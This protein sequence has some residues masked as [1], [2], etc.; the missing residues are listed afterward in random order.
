MKN[1]LRINH[2]ERKIVMD[3]TFAKNAEDT[4][5]EEYAHLQNVRRDYPSYDVILRQIK[6]NPNKECYK[7]LTYDY[8]ER[9]I[10]SHEEKENMIAVLEEYRELRL[11]SECHSKGHRYPVIKKWFLNKYPE[12]EMFGMDNVDSCVYEPVE[13]NNV[14]ELDCEERVA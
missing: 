2:I 5:S 11:I 1:T 6:K 10:L 9:Y 14:V 12:I 8:M 4:R 7:G 13:K 3:R